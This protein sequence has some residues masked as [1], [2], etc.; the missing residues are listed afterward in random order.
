[1]TIQDLLYLF[2][3]KILRKSN[4][5]S[6]EQIETLLRATYV[7]FCSIFLQIYDYVYE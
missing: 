6:A 4:S 3:N 1:M 2:D 7:R 5:F